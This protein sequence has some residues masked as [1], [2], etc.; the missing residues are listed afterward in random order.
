MSYETGL[1]KN[2]IE[3]LTDGFFAV[4]MTLLVLDISIP[5]IS[6]NHAAAGGAAVIGAELLKRLFDLWPKILC[7]GISFIVLAIYWM[8]HHRQF[9]YIKHSDRTLVWINI[10]FL[11]ATC[12]LPFSTS[13]LAEYRAQQISIFVYGG[14]SI[15]IALL[16]CIQWWYATSHYSRLVDENLDPIIK[17]T[18]LRRLVFGII[19]YLIAIGISSVYI[20]LSIFLF[21][22]ILI[23]EFLPNKMMYRITFGGLSSLTVKY[24]LIVLET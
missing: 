22:S 2:R 6:S 13:L 21:A 24:L 11:M 4:V 20:H 1:S 12:L 14:N 17:T 15:M 5:Q 8:A 23:S 3:A 16:L 19:V 9:H 7:F 10:I 18:S